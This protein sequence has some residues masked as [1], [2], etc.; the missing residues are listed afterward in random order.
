MDN[1]RNIPPRNNQGGPNNQ[2]KN[3]IISVVVTFIVALIFTSLMSYM[4]DSATK[5]EITYNQFIDLLDQGQ[6]EKVTFDANKIYIVPKT[7]GTTL[8]KTTFWTTKLDDPDL[9]TDL[10]DK[11]TDDE[12]EEVE[13]EE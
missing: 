12:A 2:K 10:K 8:I 5:K 7:D 3:K 11:K 4:F 9:I 6:V 13:T 1:N